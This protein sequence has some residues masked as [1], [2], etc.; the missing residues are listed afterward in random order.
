MPPVPEA[1]IEPSLADGHVSLTLIKVA[2]T[3][4]GFA[5]LATLPE[6]SQPFASFIYTPYLPPVRPVTV[7]GAVNGA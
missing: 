6:P 5:M 2:A 4:V 1:I 3:L 7:S